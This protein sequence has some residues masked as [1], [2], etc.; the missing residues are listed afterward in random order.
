MLRGSEQ[1]FVAA[2]LER[3]PGVK[4]VGG[5]A[6]HRQPV[7]HRDPVRHHS[8]GDHLPRTPRIGDSDGDHGRLRTGAKHGVLFK[9]A[10]ALETSARIQVVVMDKTGTLTKAEPESHRRAHKRNRR[11][12]AALV[13]AVERNSEHPLA[14]AI[15]WH[16][17]ERGADSASAERFE[18][19]PGHGAMATVAD[20]RAVVGNRRLM[21]REGID[22]GPVAARRDELADG[23]RTAV[24][25]AVD[26]SRRRHRHRR[27]TPRNSEATI[28][29]LH[30]LDIEV[31]LLRRQRTRP[32]T[33]TASGSRILIGRIT[34]VRH[35]LW[36]RVVH[37][38]RSAGLQCPADRS[39]VLR[40][41][42][43]SPPG[44]PNTGR[45]KRTPPHVAMCLRRVSRC[46][47]PVHPPLASGA[48]VR[49]G[50]FGRLES[51]SGM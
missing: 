5:L 23:G 22:L 6:T 31:G 51:R 43:R 37:P 2:R 27:R 50:S 13:S 11:Q 39:T 4:S 44:L 36:A 49:R 47:H 1:N 29:E 14:E 16:A 25:A 21:E 48:G 20:K 26:G 19:V 7:H 41:T 9:N 18:N 32:Q 45:D 12:V 46:F 40:M 10:I 15:V 28:A 33:T 3:Q 35:Q 24:L 42:T 30:E 17:K 8:R 34:G 38:A